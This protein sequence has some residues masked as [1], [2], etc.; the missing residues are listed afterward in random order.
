M[1]CTQTLNM[2]LPVGVILAVLALAVSAATGQQLCDEFT[3]GECVFNDDSVIESW[4]IPNTP[5]AP[6]T[7]QE[8]CRIEDECNYFTYRSDTETCLLYHYFDLVACGLV[9]GTKT[10]PF[11]DCLPQA[12]SPDI[13]IILN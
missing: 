13:V 5:T 6:I 9:S 3:L 8:L 4:T 7:C 2:S 12:R 11:Y 1:C 10:P